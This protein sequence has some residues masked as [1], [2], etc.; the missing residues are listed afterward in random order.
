VVQPSYANTVSELIGTTDIGS[1][2]LYKCEDGYVFSDG[3]SVNA[4]QCD[5]TKQ[6]TGTVPK[7][8]RKA[9]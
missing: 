3:S 6:W 8:A 1:Y 5:N 7:C 2:A 4:L 9:F